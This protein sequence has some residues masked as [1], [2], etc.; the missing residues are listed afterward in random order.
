VQHKIVDPE[1]GATVADGVDGEICVRGYNVLDGM[2]KRERH[3][4]FDDDGWYHTNDRG[5]LRHGC[6]FFKGRLGEMIK[7]AGANVS[8]REVEVA[9]EQLPGVELAQ[10]VGLP[11]EQRGE[12]VAAV[13]VPTADGVLDVDE[14]IERLRESIASYKVPRRFVVTTHDD[15]PLLASTKIDRRE[16]ARRLAAGELP[17]TAPG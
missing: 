15:I 11:D 10:V 14:I 8:P 4:V 5:S 9:L 16:L 6:I 7:T 12:L 3:E 13:L 1:S 2:Y 17:T